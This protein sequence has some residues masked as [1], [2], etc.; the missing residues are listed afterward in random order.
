MPDLPGTA[1]VSPRR[2]RPA[3]RE[4]G[5]LHPP[6]SST[7]E[8]RDTDESGDRAGGREALAQDVPE[9]SCNTS[10]RVAGTIP[11]PRRQRMAWAF[12]QDGGKAL[13]AGHP[14]PLGDGVGL[15]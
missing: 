12:E 8:S 10:H 11:R 4:C 13:L 2:I 15:W 7:V 5:A 1:P 14:R 3:T 6:L 9:P